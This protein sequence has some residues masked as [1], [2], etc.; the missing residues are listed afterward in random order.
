MYSEINAAVNFLN[1]FLFDK[2]PR[3]KVNL[4][5]QQLANFLLMRFEKTWSPSEPHKGSETRRIQIKVHGGIT[6][7]LISVTA[8]N[9]GLDLDEVLQQWPGK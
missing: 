7:S 1:H 3:R 8:S 2:L 5:S 9:V 6:D 4:F